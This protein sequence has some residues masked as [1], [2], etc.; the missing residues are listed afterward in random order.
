LQV[1]GTLNDTDLRSLL[2]SAQSERATG[3]LTV[4]DGDG[5]SATFYFLFGHLFHALADGKSGDDAVVG[6]LTWGTG[7]YDFD[8]KAKLP[9]DETVRSSIPELIQNAGSTSARRPASDSGPDGAARQ[10]PVEA[11]QPPPQAGPAM[12]PAPVEPA[13]AAQPEPISQPGSPTPV[14][15]QP[16]ETAAEARPVSPPQPR[17][18]VK[19]RPQP[20]VGKDPI[21]VPAGQLIYDSLKTSFVDFPRLI[22]TLEREGYTGYV[23]LLTEDANGLIF[24]RDGA[25]LECVFDSGTDTPMLGTPALRAFHEEVTH[26]HGVL[27]VVQLGGDLVEGLHDLTVARSIYSD[28]YASWIDAPALLQFLSDKGLSGS[29]MVRS[30]AGVGVVILS[31]G[32]LA[33]AYTTD[34]TEVADTAD[35]VLAL[36][37]GADAVIDV[38]ANEGRSREGL[39][40]DSVIGGNRRLEADTGPAAGAAPAAAEAPPPPA[41]AADP[42]P[43]AFAPPPP[44]PAPAPPLAPAAQP[45]APAPMAS[46]NNFQAGPEAPHD[47]FATPPPAPIPA[48]APPAPSPALSTPAP[49]PNL[50]ITQTL[51]IQ[52]SVPPSAVAA[53]TR[54]QANWDAIVAD[55]QATTEEALGNRSRKVKDVLASAERSQAGIEAAINQIPT[56]SILFV[57][58]SRLEALAAD[59]R[60]KLNSYLQ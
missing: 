34:A 31:A 13:P 6:A 28:L 26:G 5:R 49:A 55:L 7:D 12:P 51:P 29:M 40:V 3:T 42:G 4:R 19:H 59:L 47:V 38:K 8:P 37:G 36:A 48:P 45:P 39:D 35:A 53:A 15:V 16:P 23:K 10:R 57:D 9:A 44:V 60:A 17:R 20:R 32:R 1:K 46:Q 41:P 11:A 14:A 54:V 2:E 56:I 25:A 24:F 30:E 27:D 50:G 58:S 18:G 21:P 52:T 22:T 33:G 43:M